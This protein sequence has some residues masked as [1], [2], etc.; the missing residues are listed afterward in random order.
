MDH[1]TN[2]IKR[3]L[4]EVSVKNVISRMYLP[5]KNKMVQDSKESR[6]LKIKKTIQ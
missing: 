2:R 5:A 6:K 3:M 4:E 1:P